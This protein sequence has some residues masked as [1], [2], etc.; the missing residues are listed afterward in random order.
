M[1]MLPKEIYRFSEI[2][3]K[4]LM[5]FFTEIEQ[6]V[7]KFVWIHKRLCIVHAILRKKNKAGGITLLD[8]KLFKKN[9]IS[10]KHLIGKNILDSLPG[11]KKQ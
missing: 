3:I 4:I 7:L 8:V 2:P 6:T 9:I 1:P 11:K 5:A 10:L